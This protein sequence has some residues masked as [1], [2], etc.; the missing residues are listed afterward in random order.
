MRIIRN[1]TG[2]VTGAVSR[3]WDNTV[4]AIDIPDWMCWVALAVGAVTFIG[5]IVGGF[6]IAR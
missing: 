3:V 1:V 6:I 2:V 5:G 4:G